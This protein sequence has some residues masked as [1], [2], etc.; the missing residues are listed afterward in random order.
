MLA[1][2][3][4]TINSDRRSFPSRSATVERW[5]LPTLAAVSSSVQIPV[6][7]SSSEALPTRSFFSRLSST[8]RKMPREAKLVQPPPSA[9][10]ALEGSWSSRH[11]RHPRGLVDCRIVSRPKSRDAFRARPALWRAATEM[12]AEPRPPVRI[13]ASSVGIDDASR[14]HRPFD[15][16]SHHVARKDGSHV[17]PTALAPNGDQTR[18]APQTRSSPAV[19][20]G[21]DVQLVVA[22]EAVP[23][24]AEAQDEPLVEARD[25]VTGPLRAVPGVHVH[26][27]LVQ[28]PGA[29][30]RPHQEDHE[31]APPDRLDGPR[32][33]VRRQRLE[34]LQD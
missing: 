28:L 18:H 27:H 21:Q 17:T 8:S 15:N 9:P 2:P 33:D 6:I 19:L 11:S 5:D 1:D 23:A 32:H 7:S 25:D 14:A 12:P 30:D 3:L 29:L 34:V 10:V 13:A 20:P 31:A 22:D 26:G 4:S 16:R 24:P